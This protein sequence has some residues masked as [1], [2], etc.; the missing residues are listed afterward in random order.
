[1]GEL[2]DDKGS[3]PRHLRMNLPEDGRFSSASMLGAL[4]RVCAREPHKFKSSPGAKRLTASAK[5]SRGEDSS[6]TLASGGTSDA[7]DAMSVDARV[8]TMVRGLKT[9]LGPDGYAAFRA[10][11]RAYQLDDVDADAYYRYLHDVLGTS[12]P[13]LLREVLA[14]LPDERKR[15]ALDALH[16]SASA[17]VASANRGGE[18]GVST[19]S[20]SAVEVLAPGLV[21]LR[22]ALD[23][24]AQAWLAAAAFDVGESRAGDENQAGGFYTSVPGDNPGDAPVLRLN[25]GTRGRVILD[26]DAFPPRLRNLCLECVALAAGA[27][28]SH[29]HP[30]P[31]MNPTTTLV[32]FYKEGASF[33]WHRDSEDPEVQRTNRAPPIV[34]FTVGLSCDFA[35]KRR[36]EDANHGVVRLDSGDVL[37]FGGPA[38]MIVHSVL[39]VLPRTMPPGLRGKML[40]G[41]LNVT[42]RDIG[43]GV[44]DASAFP[45]YRVRYG[46]ELADDQV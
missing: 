39:R 11:G 46:G 42:V 19:P 37:L 16:A 14:T 29:E 23:L 3:S 24:D 7:R 4:W 8:R 21:V 9:L 15:S 18:G 35:Y 38:R 27:T 13:G 10:T 1:M 31:T 17:S 34:S 45:A 6:V 43:R 33:K 26:A 30:M 32:N 40:H 12:H 28:A 36:F 44:I 5:S 2:G 22:K 41:R 20:P 25:Q